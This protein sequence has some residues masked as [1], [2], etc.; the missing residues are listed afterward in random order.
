MVELVW[1]IP[2]LPLAGF[3]T[4]LVAGRRLGEPLAG[5]LATLLCAGSF[6][7]S[8][9]VFFGLLG[10][11]EEERHFVQTLFEWLPSGGLSV[12]LG[13][14]VDPLSITTTPSTSR[15]RRHWHRACGGGWRR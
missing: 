14:L 13:F 1:L 12:D 4:L 7:T 5:W 2:A 11:P 15:C 10:K 9:I 8:V 3:L 6:V